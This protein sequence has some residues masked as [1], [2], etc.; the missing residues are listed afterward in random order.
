MDY[1][2][3]LKTPYVLTLVNVI[4]REER[5]GNKVEN[6][7]VSRHLCNIDYM[8]IVKN[9]FKFYLKVNN[10][11]IYVDENMKYIEVK[12]LL[13]TIIYFEKYKNYPLEAHIKR[14]NHKKELDDEL[15]KSL[16]LQLLT[17]KYYFL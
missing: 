5:M 6:T 11:L 17:N 4:L 16:Q 13:N 2:T 10:D 8:E 14:K 3:I 9:N 1:Q 12:K 15:L 7:S